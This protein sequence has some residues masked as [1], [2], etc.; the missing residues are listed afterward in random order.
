M[1]YNSFSRGGAV[2]EVMT[3]ARYHAYHV[4]TLQYGKQ[5]DLTGLIDPVLRS[6]APYSDQRHDFHGI[7]G[8]QRYLREPQTSFF[9]APQTYPD[10]SAVFAGPYPDL[11][12]SISPYPP[13]RYDS[14]VSYQQSS[15]ASGPQSPPLTDND[16]YVDSTQGP[17]TPP[18]VAIISPY[19][20]SRDSQSPRCALAGLSSV[21]Y[22][23]VN[24]A[25]I[26]PSQDLLPV[27]VEF[28]LDPVAGSDTITPT[29]FD[30]D[31]SSSPFSLLDSPSSTVDSK[32][33]TVMAYP[34]LDDTE[35]DDKLA[36]EV[37]TDDTLSRTA[38]DDQEYKPP[39]RGKASRAPRN[40]SRHARQRRSSA[41]SRDNSTKVSKAC[42]QPRTK[43]VTTRRLL[44]SPVISDKACPHCEI[45]FSDQGSL[46]KH[47][48]AQHRRP[49]T[50]VFHF[51]GC[52]KIFANKNEWKRH[53]WAQH[54]SLHYWLCVNGPCGHGSN[55]NGGSSVAPTHG[56]I[57]R[58]KD[59]FTQHIRRMHAPEEVIKAD[60]KEKNLPSAWVAK[61]KAMQAAAF[62]LRCELPTHMRCPAQGC[63]IEFNNGSKT[64]DN[65]M[66]HV[67]VHLERAASGEESPVLFG[68]AGDEALTDWAS[69]L[70][71]QVIE[72]TRG[73]WK[74][75]QPLK[76]A[77]IEL[78]KIPDFDDVLDEDAEG[79]ECY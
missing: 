8:I 49:F 16:I 45:P 42:P 73:G 17:S 69:D 60:K 31:N 51:A 1:P 52:D 22:G 18:D 37:V 28:S 35:M 11:V 32:S 25:A 20:A 54:V 47:I 34:E 12:S 5:Q 29:P 61:E 3:D 46:Q 62:R 6:G 77:R 71:V 27:S 76:A 72:R 48:N 36:E 21:H 63:H 58:R 79:E 59:L 68:N 33:Q 2:D 26:Q 64:W 4:T 10:Q 65:R 67:A 13:F 14:P 23:C 15:A 24:P 57:F 66:E 39:G 55:Q 74:I 70:R 56:R 7:S 19:I 44:S 75:C 78:S 9:D 30:H 41:A 50:C 38:E 43:T 53:V 40:P